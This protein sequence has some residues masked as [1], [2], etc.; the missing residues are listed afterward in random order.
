MPA[1]IFIAPFHLPVTMRFVYAVAAL[2]N[3]RLG[4][5]SQ[6]PIEKL[7]PD[8]R[9][10]LAAYERV[11]DALDVDHLEA[12]V[13][14]VAKR[15]GG[16]DR[17]IGTLEQL[18]VQL[19]Q[20][21]D[22]LGI[23]GMGEEASRN[24]RDKARMK[25]VLQ[26]AGV[27]C[28][29]HR[30][31]TSAGEGWA[32]ALDVGY[33][34][35]LKP[36]DAAAAKGTFR[37]TD[38]ETLHQA[39]SALRPSPERPAVAEEFVTGRERSFE[40]VTIQ[41]KPVWFSSTLYDPPPLHV[42]ENPW[43]QWTVLMPREEETEDTRLAR[44]HALAALQALGMGTGLSHME[45][46]RRDRP[47][48]P[49][50]AISEVGA[51]PPGAQIVSLNSYAHGVDFYERWARLIVFDQ[52]DA[53]P[54]K[55]AAGVA[56]FRGQGKTRPGARVVALHGVAEAQRELGELVV[57]VK[58]PQIGQ[59]RA[60]S[61]EGEGYAIIRHPDTDVVARALR[62]LVSTVRVELG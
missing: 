56:F 45:W 53:P 44:P 59:P 10:R 22:R 5:I 49:P 17:L 7:A 11:A 3:V 21:R 2:P 58:L 38:A 16:V 12:G 31:I 4:L 26:R 48:G 36:P 27:P 60:E 33:P 61:Y 34:L 35:I 23:E 50:V 19:G 32:F 28:A 55:F 54:R 20:L 40:T 25:D 42:L 8:L 6:E 62:R 46:F 24:F 43:I 15:L 14:A 52:W 13:K 47:G 30:R 39:L 29:R 51:R 41:G 9:R 1:V 18:Q 37:V 57:D